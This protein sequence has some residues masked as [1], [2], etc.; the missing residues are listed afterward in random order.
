MTNTFRPRL[1]GFEDRITPTL[2]IWGDGPALIS[3][4]GIPVTTPPVEELQAMPDGAWVMDFGEMLNLTPYVIGN[5]Q[6]PQAGQIHL[7][8]Y[9]TLVEIGPGGIPTGQ[10][11]YLE[12]ETM[13]QAPHWQPITPAIYGV[14]IPVS[15]WLGANGF[16]VDAPPGSSSGSNWVVNPVMIDPV[17]GRIA[18]VTSFEIVCTGATNVN[19]QLIPDYAQIAPDSYYVGPTIGLP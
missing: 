3:P 16:D 14:T 5:D 15:T 13:I 12:S 8:L 1:E 4:L 9:A 19:G 11:G 10:V 18:I 7:T 2:L 6:N 17:S